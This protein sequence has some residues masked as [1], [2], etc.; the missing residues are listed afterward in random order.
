MGDGRYGAQRGK[1][2]WSGTG[3][4]LPPGA[5]L[6]GTEHAHFPCAAARGRTAF[7]ENVGLFF[8]TQNRMLGTWYND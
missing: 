2:T 4:A 3:A 8:S 7:M 1:I 6:L 5:A